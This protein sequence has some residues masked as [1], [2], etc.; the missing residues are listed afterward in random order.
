M[1]PSKRRT[2]GHLHPGQDVM[3]SVLSEGKCAMPVSDYLSIPSSNFITY[4]SLVIVIPESFIQTH[5]EAVAAN[6]VQKIQRKIEQLQSPSLSQVNELQDAAAIRDWITRA[7]SNR[8][9]TTV[10]PETMG[11]LFSGLKVPPPSDP[12]ATLPDNLSTVIFLNPEIRDTSVRATVFGGEEALSR[13]VPGVTILEMGIDHMDPALDLVGVPDLVNGLMTAGAVSTG[14]FNEANRDAFESVWQDLHYQFDLPTAWEPGKAGTETTPARFV[15]RIGMEQET[16]FVVLTRESRTELFRKTVMAS[17]R[18]SEL[19]LPVFSLEV[20]AFNNQVE[21]PITHEMVP[22]QYIEMV[23]GPL[24]TEEHMSPALWFAKR[25]L[26]QVIKESHNTNM[27]EVIDRY[28]RIIKTYPG[29]QADRYLLIPNEDANVEDI[30]VAKLPGTI[31]TFSNQAS[32]TFPYAEMGSDAFI[33]SIENSRKPYD[34]APLKAKA[35]AFVDSLGLDVVSPEMR[36]FGFHLFFSIQQVQLAG[37]EGKGKLHYTYLPRFSL[38]DA[39]FAVLSDTEVKALYEWYGQSANRQWLLDQFA[40]INMP[41]S[42]SLQVDARLDNTLSVTASQRLSSQRAQLEVSANTDRFSPVPDHT[43]RLVEHSHP[44][45]ES[46][47]PFV[48]RDGQYYG[49]AEY[50]GHMLRMVQMADQP[51]SWFYGPRSEM[52]HSLMAETHAVTPYDKAACRFSESVTETL[53]LWQQSPPDAATVDAKLESLRLMIPQD[54]APVRDSQGRMDNACREWWYE[55]HRQWAALENLVN[56][57]PGQAPESLTEL[58]GRLNTAF[59]MDPASPPPAYG[60]IEFENGAFTTWRGRVTLAELGV[61]NEWVPGDA[62]PGFEVSRPQAHV[63][64]Y[65]PVNEQ[66]LSRTRFAMT[67][68]GRPWPGPAQAAVERLSPYDTQLI[69]YND[70]VDGMTSLVIPQGGEAL[71]ETHMVYR[72]GTDRPISVVVDLAEY[73]DRPPRQLVADLTRLRESYTLLESTQAGRAQLDALL[74]SSGTQNARYGDSEIMG[75]PVDRLAGLERS[76]CVIFLTNGQEGWAEIPVQG[77]EGALRVAAVSADEEGPY[78]D[79]LEL[80]QRLFNMNQGYHLDDPMESLNLTYTH[81]LE[82]LAN[83]HQVCREL[84]LPL[85]ARIS[86]DR[87]ENLVPLDGSTPLL[88]EAHQVTTPRQMALANQKLIYAEAAFELAR[89]QG[90]DTAGLVKETEGL[91]ALERMVTDHCD[92]NNKPAILRRFRMIQQRFLETVDHQ[93]TIDTL[94]DAELPFDGSPM[95]VT[96][97]NELAGELDLEIIQ[98]QARVAVLTNAREETPRVREAVISEIKE[99]LQGIN[100][101][102]EVG[103]WLENMPEQLKDM[104][105][106]NLLE[107]HG[108]NPDNEDVIAVLNEEHEAVLEALDR[109]GLS[110]PARTTLMV[111]LEQL[112]LDRINAQGPDLPGEMDLSPLRSRLVLDN[113]GPEV[114]RRGTPR[115]EVE[116][117][118]LAEALENQPN[119]ARAVELWRRNTD[120]PPRSWRELQTILETGRLSNLGEGAETFLTRVYDSSG[121]L[122]GICL[123]METGEE[124]FRVLAA[125]TSPEAESQVVTEALLDTTRTIYQGENDAHIYLRPDTE[126]LAASARELFFSDEARFSLFGREPQTRINDAAGRLY[127]RQRAFVANVFHE[128]EAM[129]PNLPR[130]TRERIQ[131]LADRWQAFRRASSSERM[132]EFQEGYLKF[133][134]ELGELAAAAIHAS[135]RGTVVL[136]RE[137]ARFMYLL[138]NTAPDTLEPQVL[139]E[140]VFPDQA[141]AIILLEP[142]DPVARQAAEFLRSKHPELTALYRYENGDLI[143]EHSSSLNPEKI[144]VVGHGRNGRVAGQTGAEIM[145]LLVDQEIVNPGERIGRISVVAC[146]PDDPA[147][148]DVEGAPRSRF[149]EEMLRTANDLNVNLGTV[150]TRS[151]LVMVDEQGRKWIGQF[152]DKGVLAWTR[153]QEETKSVTQ[154]MD[155]GRFQTIRVPVE[156][157]EVITR[158]GN[159]AD[160]LGPGSRGRVVRFFYGIQVGEDGLPV[161]PEERISDADLALVRQMMDTDL[162]MGIVSLDK[163]EVRIISTED[164]TLANTREGEAAQSLLDEFIGGRISDTDL[165]SGYQAL[166]REEQAAL[167]S[168]LLDAYVQAEE[169]GLLGKAIEGLADQIRRQYEAGTLS[170]SARATAEVFMEQLRLNPTQAPGAGIRRYVLT[171][172]TARLALETHGFNPAGRLVVTE[173]ADPVTQPGTDQFYSHEVFTLNRNPSGRNPGFDIISQALKNQVAEQVATWISQA[174]DNGIS[175]SELFRVR[176]VLNRNGVGRNS[177]NTEPTGIVITRDPDGNIAAVGIF[178]HRRGQLTMEYTVSDPRPGSDTPPEGSYWTGAERENTLAAVQALSRQ[179]PDRTIQML[180]VNGEEDGIFGELCVETRDGSPFL[181]QDRQGLDQAAQSLYQRKLARVTQALTELEHAAQGHLSPEEQARLTLLRTDL[182]AMPDQAGMDMAGF[183]A[184]D[185]ALVE[186]RTRLVT[187]TRELAQAHEAVLADLGGNIRTLDVNPLPPPVPPRTG[188]SGDSL[189]AGAEGLLQEYFFGRITLEGLHQAYTNLSKEG[190]AKLASYLVETWDA[191]P[192]NLDLLPAM[193]R[194]QSQILEHYSE[195]R[196]TRPAAQILEGRMEAIRQAD[197]ARSTAEPGSETTLYFHADR[198]RLLFDSLT[199]E[200]AEIAR[201]TEGETLIDPSLSP[202]RAQHYDLNPDARYMMRDGLGGP[203]RVELYDAQ[204]HTDVAEALANWKTALDG[205]SSPGADAYARIVQAIDKGSIRSPEGVRRLPYMAVFR[206]PDTGEIAAIGLYSDVRSTGEAVI[207]AILVDPTATDAGGR[208]WG[209]QREALMEMVNMINQRLQGRRITLSTSDPELERAARDLFFSE[210]AQAGFLTADSGAAIST[211]EGLTALYER[212]LEVMRSVVDSFENMVADEESQLSSQSEEMVARIRRSLDWLEARAGRD[213]GIFTEEFGSQYRTLR[214]DMGDFAQ[215]ARVEDGTVYTEYHT[216]EMENIRRGFSHTPESMH[217]YYQRILDMVPDTFARKGNYLSRLADPLAI[218]EL[219]NELAAHQSPEEFVRTMGPALDYVRDNIRFSGHA[220]QVLDMLAPLEA[221]HPEHFARLTENRPMV[222]EHLGRSLYRNSSRYTSQWVVELDDPDQTI[223]K[224]VNKRPDSSRGLRWDGENLTDV[225]GEKVTLGANSRLTLIGHSNPHTMADFTATGLVD[226]LINQNILRPGEAISRISLVGCNLAGFEPPPADTGSVRAGFVHD[227][228]VEARARGLE[229]GSVSLRSGYVLVDRFGRKYV[230]ILNPDGTER[231]TH[232]NGERKL[233]YSWDE[234]DKVVYR[235]ALLEEGEVTRVN[236]GADTGTLVRFRNG[237]QVEGA[238]TLSAEQRSSVLDRYG[239][240]FTGSLWLDGDEFLPNADEHDVPGLNALDP[241][242]LPHVETPETGGTE[243][244]GRSPRT[245]EEVLVRLRA[246][247]QVD[248]YGRPVRAGAWEALSE[249]ELTRVREQFGETYTGR[250]RVTPSAITEE[251]T[252]DLLE[253]HPDLSDELAQ[254]EAF[255]EHAKQLGSES[256]RILGRRTAEQAMA[257]EKIQALTEMLPEEVRNTALVQDHLNNISDGVA[258]SVEIQMEVERDHMRL[259]KAVTEKIAA[260]NRRTGEEWVVDPSHIEF[261][262]HDVHFQIVRKTDLVSVPE[263]RPGEVVEPVIREGATRVRLVINT[264]GIIKAPGILT[265]KLALARGL[266]ERAARFSQSPKGVALNGVTMAGG[267]ALAGIGL[268]QAIRGLEDRRDWQTIFGGVTA[269][270]FSGHAAVGAFARLMSTQMGKSLISGASTLART[271]MNSAIEGIARIT[272]RAVEEISM[273]VARIGSL[274]A[275]GVSTVAGVVGEIIPFVG[276]AVGIVMIGLDAYHLF[277]AESDIERVQYGVDMVF[278]AAVT[279]IDL[280]G[281]G[282]PP[283]QIVTAPLALVVNIVRMVFDSAIMEVKQQLD[284]LPEDASDADKAKAVLLGIGLGIKDFILNITPWGALVETAKIQAQHFHDQNTLNKLNDLTT[285][286]GVHPVEGV[287]GEKAVDFN[288]GDN[289]WNAGAVNFH[290]GEAGQAS[291]LSIGNIPVREL[292]GGDG[293]LAARTVL[294]RGVLEANADYII[295]SVGQ[296][297]TLHTAKATAHMFFCIPVY[298]T[299]VLNGMDANDDSLKGYYVGNSRDNTFVGVSIASFADEDGDDQDTLDRKAEYRLNIKRYHHTMFGRE[300][301]DVFVLGESSYTIKGGEGADTYV[302]RAKYNDTVFNRTD[303]SRVI[304]DNHATDGVKDTVVLENATL[305]GLSFI[306]NHYYDSLRINGVD[307][308]DAF[309]EKRARGEYIPDMTCVQDTTIKNY[310]RGEDYQHLQFKTKDGFLVE[311]DPERMEKRGVFSHFLQAEDIT[312]YYLQTGDVL[313]SMSR[314]LYLMR[315]S[316]ADGMTHERTMVH[317]KSIMGNEMNNVLIGNHLDNYIHGG[318]GYDDLRG[319]GGN[320]TLV[321]GDPGSDFLTSAPYRVTKLW[322]ESGNDTLI[323]SARKNELYG[324]S[325]SDT[326]ILDEGITQVTISDEADGALNRVRL[327]I[328]KENMRVTVNAQGSLVIT[329]NAHTHREITVKG[330]TTP[331]RHARFEFHT[332]DGFIYDR[333]AD[334]LALS[335]FDGNA[336]LECLPDDDIQTY[337]PS[338]TGFEVEVFRRAPAESA[339]VIQP[340]LSPLTGALAALVNRIRPMTTEDMRYTAEKGERIGSGRTASLG[341]SGGWAP[342]FLLHMDQA[343]NFLRWLGC[344]LDQD[345]LSWAFEAELWFN[346]INPPRHQYLVMRRIRQSLGI[347]FPPRDKFNNMQDILDALV[348]GGHT[349]PQHFFER[350]DFN[351]PMVD[352]FL[353]M[354]GLGTGNMRLDEV[355]VIRFSSHVW[356]DRGRHDFRVTSSMGAALV[357]GGET[358]IRG[359]DGLNFALN[360]RALTKNG[361][362]EVETAGFYKVELFYANTGNTKLPFCGELRTL[363][364]ARPHYLKLE[365]EDGQGE[366]HTLGSLDSDIVVRNPAALPTGQHRRGTDGISFDARQS[367]YK[368]VVRIAGTDGDDWLRGNA[369]GNQLIG[370][371]GADTMAGGEGADYYH[372]D[373]A[374][375]DRINNHAQ[376]GEIDQIYVDADYND[377]SFAMSGL[378]LSVRSGSTTIAQLYKYGESEDYRHAR[379]HTRDG[380]VLNVDPASA[381]GSDPIAVHRVGRDFSDRTQGITWSAAADP[382]GAEVLVITG[383]DHN[384]TLT[385]NGL[386]N[387]LIGGDGDDTLNGLGGNDTLYADKGEDTL[388]GGEGSDSYIILRDCQRA[389][390][391]NHQTGDETNILRLHVNLRD[392]HLSRAG[393]DLLILAMF[394]NNNRGSL[395][396]IEDWFIDESVRHLA[397]VTDDDWYFTIRGDRPAILEKE[398]NFAAEEREGVNG[399]II[400]MAEI[401]P[402]VLRATGTRG[403]D[404]ILGNAK[405]NVIIGNGGADTLKGNA[406]ADVYVIGRDCGEVLVDNTTLD[407]DHEVIML[408]FDHG[409]LGETELDGDDLILHTQAGTRIRLKDWKISEEARD[410]TLMTDGYTYSIKEDGEL[411]LQSVDL[412]RRESGSLVVLEEGAISASGSRFADALMG[413][414]EDNHLSDGGG[415]DGGGNDQLSGGNGRDLYEVSVGVNSGHID[416]LDSQDLLALMGAVNGEDGH[417]VVVDNRATDGKTD[418]LLVKAWASS[419]VRHLRFGDHL[420]LYAKN[421]DQPELEAGEL[422]LDCVVVK[423]Y[424]KGADRRHLTLITPKDGIET[425]LN[426]DGSMG[427]VKAID[428]SELGSGRTRLLYDAAYTDVVQITDSRFRDF[429]HGNDQDNLM[430]TRYGSDCFSGG[431]GQDTFSITNINPSDAPARV[432]TLTNGGTDGKTDLVYLDM[433]AEHLRCSKVIPGGGLQIQAAG[434]YVVLRDWQPQE[435]EA[436]VFQIATR[437]GVSYNIEADGR[438]TVASVDIS[439]SKDHRVNGA[440]QPRGATQESEDAEAVRL[441]G[442]GAMAIRSYYA[443]AVYFRGGEASEFICGNN[444]DNVI[445]S[446][447]TGEDAETLGGIGGSDTYVL[448]AAGNYTIDNFATDKKEDSVKLVQAF[449]QVSLVR[450]GDDLVL[451]AEDLRVAVRR[452]FLD[453]KQRHIQFSTGDGIVFTVS[454][455]FLSVPDGTAVVPTIRSIDLS[456]STEDV[457]VDLTSAE[458]FGSARMAVTQF[459]GSLTTVNR[460]VFGDL[461][462]NIRTGQKDD[463]ITAGSGNQVIASDAGADIIRSGA[464][465]DL[466][467]AG[468]GNDTIYAGSDQDFIVGG[469]GADYIDGGLGTDSISFSGDAVTETGVTVNLTTGQG[470][471]ADAQGD[472]YVNVEN[473]YGTIYDDILTGNRFNNILAGGAGDDTLKGMGGNDILDPGAGEDTVDGGEGIDLVRYAGLGCGVK[474]NLADGTARV[475]GSSEIVV[476]QTLRNVENVMGTSHADVITGDDNANLVIASLGVDVIDLAGGYDTVDYRNLSFDTAETNGIWVDLKNQTPRPFTGDGNLDDYLVQQLSNVEA[477][478]GSRLNDR[479]YGTNEDDVLGGYLG[480]DIVR[481]RGGND[482]IYAWGDGDRLYGGAGVDTVD[483]RFMAQG[484]VV[485]LTSGYGNGLDRLAGFENISGTLFNDILEGDANANTLYGSLGM[486]LLRGMGGNDLFKGLGDGD[487]MEGGEGMDTADFTLAASGSWIVMGV[488]PLT[489]AQKRLWERMENR[490]DYLSGIET[491][492]GSTKADVVETSSLSETIQTKGGNDIILG[493]LGNDTLNGG[494]GKDTVSYQA[495]AHGVDIDLNTNQVTNRGGD[496]FTDTLISIEAVRG[497]DHDD[498]VTGHATR[499]DLI[500]GSAGTDTVDGQGGTDTLDFSDQATD[501][502][503]TVTAGSQAG[504]YTVGFT[505]DDEDAETTA[506]NMEIIKGSRK[507]DVFTGGAHNDHFKGGFGD[508]IL[509]GG[510]GADILDGGKGSDLYRFGRGDESATIRDRGGFDTLSL[511]GYSVNE[512]AFWK[513]GDD[514]MISAG[515]DTLRIEDQTGTDDPAVDRVTLSNGLTLNSSGIDQLVNAMATFGADNGIDIDSASDIRENSQLMSLAVSAWS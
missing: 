159:P 197:L 91:E 77:A 252:L 274:V 67:W 286:F 189:V 178:A 99:L 440:I 4:G 151:A 117:H 268:L 291:T 507:K 355:G 512:I 371:L 62:I 17:T 392:V 483:Y 513:D 37:G 166:P 487:R 498:R 61:G 206:D 254:W 81:Q 447:G 219:V 60:D 43:G 404:T 227:F 465:D 278:D 187:T 316:M 250:I 93:E 271:A 290:L 237:E 317:L 364:D 180:S 415:C 165:V 347:P 322:G 162:P 378:D 54:L 64:E 506:T 58:S 407:G 360:Q 323:S 400:D 499:D 359:E 479:I 172:E 326:Y 401:A 409:Q 514:L 218:R 225:A 324:G 29:R 380:W 333:K 57:L 406:G 163:G 11:E 311:L 241:D 270:Y 15:D 245:G 257:H 12:T 240:D 175:S 444:K 346:E 363:S 476:N 171:A 223:F 72:L 433:D 160:G 221:S 127:T 283:A 200:A 45:P 136:S 41:V 485:S 319:G 176:G 33:R 156:E 239:R 8:V 320:D 68:N 150:S 228:M 246:G 23:M 374:S 63:Y 502:G 143:T 31:E 429:Y 195:N 101:P 269:S 98:W 430:V 383:S 279:I 183:R 315:I 220:N 460:V 56:D 52:L 472:T 125:A 464:G 434:I 413:N 212:R 336:Y 149:A 467:Y 297:H 108:Q 366:F 177:R 243:A 134:Q 292:E 168:R 452:Y 256:A 461:S 142:N 314:H 112:R 388:S 152:D 190:Q 146:A 448:D 515:T 282:F 135:D 377:L 348:K 215:R 44:N 232:G 186:F 267:L 321:G 450:E 109:G 473:V 148:A 259:M 28:N 275:R 402:E 66:G 92:A 107:A 399:R 354:P 71:D 201:V 70:P 262:G 174:A 387:Q 410:F 299:T 426:A 193:E 478:W 140:E 208:P 145:E 503:V 288:A 260:Y 318:V 167:C 103:L 412:S 110:R 325:D 417:L 47:R 46:R 121:D 3:R 55:V 397:V 111:R 431:N 224:L 258:E 418:R 423:R 381:D 20:D 78:A 356:L 295:M 2:G 84:G 351:A 1:N 504:A 97:A 420:V 471:G 427:R 24:R 494:A 468:S 74:A 488:S 116:T 480:L 432:V 216:G 104:A 505:M 398:L 338:Q 339:G 48:V 158:P 85:R 251:P 474:V 303:Y 144:I 386:D 341:F 222:S 80:A 233:I 226:F 370:G 207:E 38:E 161:E 76:A 155:N 157:G 5:S 496:D 327:P 26:L 491:L 456:A 83:E 40:E 332:K 39:L 352:N 184:A 7:V 122:V 462:G 298:S 408:T 280:I 492:V 477:V 16:P 73:A 139:F 19:G 106:S 436:P 389:T 428:D 501:D 202:W 27:G 231:Y 453:E 337:P 132:A 361:F 114:S 25:T 469:Q 18:D 164:P 120:Q 32:I 87:V 466:I 153:N 313:I 211:R 442:T 235:K 424:F 458:D 247:L 230:G 123:A 445:V 358:I 105:L 350:V 441:Y 131:N 329:D 129:M 173:G 497:S 102:D 451:T 179:Y 509:D 141:R 181:S 353:N 328:L 293:D 236:E 405:D 310:F 345:V 285:Y 209:I 22:K 49:I 119:L 372:V 42:D 357:V 34:Y 416:A 248:A 463:E 234:N 457:I 69:I 185:A 484:V 373:G 217:T 192:T 244:P 90:L 214:R 113:M 213:N 21:H 204:T 312:G 425:A 334:G 302:I 128:L 500:L 396:T 294:W 307:V 304:I 277:T 265:R 511:E 89:S 376:D 203:I 375:L 118:S 296:S 82:A 367:G 309:R 301:N 191:G 199:Q 305:A 50:R 154:R 344:E 14:Q 126:N 289:S 88:D 481:G 446:G 342:K 414:A 308:D 490:Y 263:S 253:A 421:P 182:S 331:G 394:D 449:A 133:R 198:S 53:K 482:T 147:T 130:A 276:A 30:Q 261:D 470:R 330:W 238:Q 100:T 385:G 391:R 169:T 35:N 411:Q 365:I 170:D 9:E 75:L 439:R 124:E 273:G 59:G 493:S 379:F 475:N 435:G 229:I 438:L 422:P 13:Q 86:L 115:Y 455:A 96:T 368:D 489:D 390:I 486:D 79:H 443:D 403:A 384:D 287:K 10:R 137:Q 454:D 264:I 272:G 95:A 94:I 255:T 138:G 508:D 188:R 419:Q 343:K 393:D 459:T 6:L 300:G 362:L 349:V 437:D 306:G 242:Q 266:A 65:R 495:M 249:G 281:V 395:L 369:L 196:L 51:R 335:G 36:A 205:G 340:H 210:S 510:R 284:A 382:N 194:F